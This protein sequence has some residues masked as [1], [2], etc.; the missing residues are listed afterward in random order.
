MF[1]DREGI[2]KLQNYENQYSCRWEIKGMYSKQNS[3]ILSTYR[4]FH[5]FLQKNLKFSYFEEILRIIIKNMPYIEILSRLHIA[6]AE[7]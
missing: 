5:F 2:I 7:L 6:W 3:L 4:K 1:T